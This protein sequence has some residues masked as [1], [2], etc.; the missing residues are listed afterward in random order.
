MLDIDLGDTVI[1]SCD[2][3]IEIA[4]GSS[5]NIVRNGTVELNSGDGI[6]VDGCAE[7]P[8]DNQIIGTTVQNNGRNGIALFAG[9]GNEVIG[10]TITGNNSGQTTGG[11]GG[12]NIMNGSGA[13][14]TSRIYSNGCTGV[15]LDDSA[16][17]NI[18]GNLIYGNPEGIRVALVSDVTIASNTITA[19]ADAGIVIEDGAL[20]MVKYNIL[21]G[22][23]T[24]VDPS[25]DVSLEGDFEPTNLIE[26]DIGTV[27]QI[28]LP[29][30]N[31]S[32][33]PLFCV[34]NPSGC[35]APFED[36]SLQRTSLCIDG[37]TV[38]EPGI[39]LT[40][41]SRPKGDSW[42]M[43]AIETSS[44][45]DADDDGLPDPWEEFYFGGSTD[46]ATCGADDDYDG[47]GVSNL[48]EYLEG[49]NPDN[50]V[51]V[52]I[53]SPATSPHFTNDGSITIS[54]TS[55]NAD[56]ITVTNG[57]STIRPRRFLECKC[58]P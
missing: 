3:G 29:P 28:D 39:D 9:F 23:G 4:A 41:S 35:D 58:Q 34:A 50:P 8:D 32:V 1:S 12:V 14:K 36:Y 38:T 44:F 52:R 13:V 31:L 6:L 53:T 24:G 27:N 20:P 11:Y 54:G 18:S 7:T 45:R 22:N 33:D 48:Q 47:D 40:G 43:G 57:G 10:C 15:Y 49:A 21:Y 42:D 26:N 2:T 16:V 17:A 51:Y 56:S 25:T 37:T 55:I 46:C 19:N 30:T 5:N